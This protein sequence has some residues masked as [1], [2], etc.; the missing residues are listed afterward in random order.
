MISSKELRNPTT[1]SSTGRNH[2][3]AVSWRKTVC[4]LWGLLQA[5]PCP[6]NCGVFL[7]AHASRVL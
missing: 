7:T 5:D 1:R 3:T 6:F 4:G 2:V